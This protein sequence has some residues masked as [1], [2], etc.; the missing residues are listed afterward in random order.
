MTKCKKFDCDRLADGNFPCCG[1]THGVAYRNEKRQLEEYQ[2][3]PGYHFTDFY[4]LKDWSLEKLNYYHGKL[5]NT[6]K[7]FN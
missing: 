3:A 6:N 2:E 7:L 4:I 5:Q 1:M